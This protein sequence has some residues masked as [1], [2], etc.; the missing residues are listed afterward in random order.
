MVW[1]EVDDQGARI[2]INFLIP[3][4][5]EKLASSIQVKSN[6]I[7]ANT[8]S[9]SIEWTG[10]QTCV[11]TLEEQGAVK[12]QD[13]IL[14]IQKAPT[15][16]RNI[17]KSASIPVQFQSNVE[18][19]EPREEILITTEEPFYIRFNT[20][21]DART[22]NKYLQSDATFTIKAVE[23]MGEDGKTYTDDTY[24]EF[25]PK[26]QL[27]NDR[28]YLLSFRKGMPSKAGNLLQDSLQ[29]V[30]QTDT[31]PLI[32]RII[33]ADG[34]KWVGLYPRITVESKTPMETAYIEIAGERL[35]GTKRSQYRVDFYLSH[36]LE[37]D[38]AYTAKVQIQAPSGELSPKSEVT[39][40]TVPIT[41]DRIWAEIILGRSHEIRIYQGT[42]E[43][44]RFV[45]SGGTATTPTPSGTFYLQ[46]KEDSYYDDQ[47]NE[48]G[49]YAMQLSEGIIIHGMARDQNWELKYNVYNRLGEGQTN[50]KLILKEED[51][52]W[53]Y[54]I[55]PNDAMIIIHP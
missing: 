30:V 40:Q 23:V 8:F 6:K 12:G 18:I 42:T 43:L 3:M 46:G 11:I 38:Q 54:E 48:G 5:Q 31:V 9:S 50:G 33:P 13:V 17:S 16:Y 29:V 41:N 26:A 27:E 28:K 25:T 52:K 19:V 37:A 55:L 34:S 24:F 22:L 36:V 4:D 7:Y 51:A 14:L 1:T 10:P 20:P 53:L 15:Q 32:E 2:T 47:I 45:C 35:Q 49:N 39:F 21:M 44:K